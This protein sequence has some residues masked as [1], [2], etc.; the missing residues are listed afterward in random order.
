MGVFYFNDTLVDPPLSSAAGVG[1]SAETQ[2]WNVPQFTPID[3]HDPV[4]GRIYRVSAGGVLSIAR[5]TSSLTITPRIGTTV[6]GGTTMGASPV[7]LSGV[8]FTS[9]PW[10]LEFIAVFQS[11]GAPGANSGVIGEGMFCCCNA[12]TGNSEM[13]FAL[14]GTLATADVSI[15]QGISIGATLSVN[16]G[17]MTTTFAFIQSLT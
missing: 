14:G 3:A 12:S 9:Q 5:T 4:A 11:V 6:A 16:G 1:P 13:M 8:I 17:T 2:L 15:N 7:K 10:W